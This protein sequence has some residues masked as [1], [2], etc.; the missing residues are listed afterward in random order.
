MKAAVKS[1]LASDVEA[2]ASAWIARRDAGMTALEEAEFTRW[3]ALPRHAAALARHEATWRIFNRPLSAGQGHA[4][5]DEFRARF[6]RQR[7]RRVAATLSAVSCLLM[8]GFV[9]RSAF[10][11]R[12]ESAPGAI[13][14]VV[15]PEKRTLPD[16]SLVEL[17]SGAEIAVD[18]S[19]E[20]RRVSLLKGETHYQVA[21]DAAR[22]FIVEVAGV[23]VRAVGTAFSVELG[24]KSVAILVTEGRVAVAAGRMAEDGSQTTE[25]GDQTSEI[26]SETSD[27]TLHP[28]SAGAHSERRPLT[29]S[30]PYS[31]A[32]WYLDAGSRLVV[33]LSPEAAAPPVAVP[34]SAPEIAQSLAWRAPRLEFSAAPLAEAISLMN[35][36]NRTQ[37]V[38]TDP[39]L[40]A[41]EVSGYFRADNHE[42]FLGL[43]EQGL[44][45]KSERH[46][47][48]IILRK[49]P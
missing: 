40:A 24:R 14:V 21:E 29:S 9:W 30:L 28:H 37:F 10:S 27:G 22:P 7:R 36:Y 43:I 1:P 46:G 4:L 32:P 23:E 35:R 18:Y 31:L 42:T 12:A 5:A 41:L 48:T 49:A 16:G 45:L 38:I 6:A 13:A 39:S 11:E 8:A 20:F 2:A 19:G 25:V 26:R 47:D 3:A 15:L 17:K 44:G 33:D 34:V